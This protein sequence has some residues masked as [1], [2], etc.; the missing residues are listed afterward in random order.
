MGIAL[1]AAQRAQIPTIVLD[2]SQ[3]AIDR[4][5]KLRGITA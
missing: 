3:A 1:V 2:S 4:A 5:L